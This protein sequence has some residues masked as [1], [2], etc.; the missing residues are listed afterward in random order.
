VVS[1]LAQIVGRQL[2]RQAVE[3][4]ADGGGGRGGG[5]PAEV[6]DENLDG[7]DRSS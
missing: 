3:P 5:R 1:H 6:F 7:R 2:A 4:V